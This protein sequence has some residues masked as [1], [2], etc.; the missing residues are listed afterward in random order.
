MYYF[1]YTI[2]TIDYYD[3]YEEVCLNPYLIGWL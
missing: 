3:Y 2:M 1:Q